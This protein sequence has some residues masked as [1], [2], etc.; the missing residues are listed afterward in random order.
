MRKIAQNDLSNCGPDA[1]LE[2]ALHEGTRRVRVRQRR[3]LAKSVIHCF[4]DAIFSSK[5][6]QGRLG[7]KKT[8]LISVYILQG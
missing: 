7:T 1:A 4:S 2:G 3:V 8:L 6:I 5:C